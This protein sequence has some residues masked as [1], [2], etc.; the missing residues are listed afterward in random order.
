VRELKTIAEIAAERERLEKQ[1]DSVIDLMV[2]ALPAALGSQPA[3]VES[4]IDLV[5]AA[6]TLAFSNGQAVA[7][8]AQ[9]ASPFQ[10]AAP[11]QPAALPGPGVGFNACPFKEATPIGARFKMLLWG[12][13]GAGKTWLAL[14]FPKP[15]VI[16]LEKGTEQ[17]GGR[18][19]FSVLPTVEAD[20]VGSAIEWLL[21]NKHDYQTLVIDP[22]TVYWEALQKKWS[23]IFLSRNRSSKGFKHE[24]YEM[25]VKDWNTLKSEHKEFIRNIHALDMNVIV[26]CR[27]KPLY[28]ASGENFMKLVGETFD[29]EKSLP[30]LFDVVV[31][32][33]RSG[34]GKYYAKATKDRSGR[35]PQEPFLSGYEAFAKM[36]S[37]SLAQRPAE[38]IVMID[39]G[40]AAEIELLRVQ[41]GI[42]EDVFCERL[43]AY[44]AER[45]CNLTATNAHVILEK[46]RAAAAKTTTKA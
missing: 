2:N 6:P 19:K 26:T 37:E 30:Y 11:A 5:E 20:S 8:P 36:F 3:S 22:V 40:Q 32:V 28:D 12:A 35:L 4:A 7:A 29:G 27:A 31:Q 38:P 15:C 41:L 21:S 42:A 23:D 17:Y 25:Q 18:F 24:F 34:E 9:P 44:G 14:Q 43:K 16:D 13:S 39:A 33:W 45:A 10:A 1:V 46:L